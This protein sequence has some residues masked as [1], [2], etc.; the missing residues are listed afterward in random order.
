MGRALLT[1]SH[2]GPIGGRRAIL[3]REVGRS[4]FTPMPVPPVAASTSI[5]D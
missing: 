2:D 5:E 1:G 3:G 4:E